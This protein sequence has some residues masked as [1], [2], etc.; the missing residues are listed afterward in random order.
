[1]VAVDLNFKAPLKIVQY[2]DPIL[3]GKNK[4]IDFLFDDNLKKLTDEMF[5][6]MYK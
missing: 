6:V 5:D 4:R 1:M 3:R 2:P